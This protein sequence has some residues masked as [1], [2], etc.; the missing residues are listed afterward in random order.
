MS[1]ASIQKQ[2]KIVIIVAAVIILASVFLTLAVSGRLGGLLGSSEGRGY[3]NITFTDAVLTC[4]DYAVKAFGDDLRTLEVDDHSSRFDQR[5]F[6]YKIFLKVE[7]PAAKQ[8]P[9]LS[10][11]YVNCFVRSSSGRISKYESYEDKEQ[12]VSPVT[13]DD[14]NLFGWPR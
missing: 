14:T 3:Q 12:K 10:L 4:R 13:G 11:H 1:R 8:L 2:N 7:T 5:E 6:V 9:G